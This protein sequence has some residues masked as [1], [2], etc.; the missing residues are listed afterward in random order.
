MECSWR[1]GLGPWAQFKARSYLQ[2]Q[3][4]TRR[5]V[6]GLAE[7]GA[8]ALPSGG[9]HLQKQ[10]QTVGGIWRTKAGAGGAIEADNLRGLFPTTGHC[11]AAFTKHSLDLTSVHAYFCLNSPAGG[12]A[13]A[14]S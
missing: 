13:G 2:T 10:C 11:L 3:L 5:K 8:G 9:G 12:A 7:V 6:P 4:L 14:P 1:S